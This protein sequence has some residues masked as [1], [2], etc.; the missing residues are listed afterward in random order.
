MRISW[1]ELIAGSVGLNDPHVIAADQNEILYDY[2]LSLN[3]PMYATQSPSQE[4]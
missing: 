2:P 1:K 4:I 3:M